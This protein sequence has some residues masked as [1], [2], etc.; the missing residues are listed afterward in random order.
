M[1]PARIELPGQAT[2]RPC[3]CRSLSLSASQLYCNP[4]PMQF[5]GALARGP[6]PGRLLADHAGRAGDLAET[7]HLCRELS[8][9][10]PATTAAHGDCPRRAAMR[11]PTLVAVL[12]ALAFVLL[13]AAGYLSS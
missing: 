3:P 7:E 5:L 12:S 1:A 6:S 11:A 4:G 8:A 13:T 9:A 2:E 10:L